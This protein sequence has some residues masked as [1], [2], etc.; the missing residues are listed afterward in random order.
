MTELADIVIALAILLSVVCWAVSAWHIVRGRELVAYAGRRPVPWSAVDLLFSL[1]ILVFFQALG[2]QSA[3]LLRLPGPTD[4]I[5]RM[6]GA[7]AA[8]LLAVAASVLVVVWNAGAKTRDLGIDGRRI[9]ADV[10]LGAVAFLMLAP[11]V[12]ALQDWLVRWFPSE[13]PLLSLLAQHGSL[14][15]YLS[16]GFSAVIVAPI[17]EEWLFR[18][19]LQGWI[20]RLM[21]PTEPAAKAAPAR[22]ASAESS[23][24][25]PHATGETR[26]LFAAA[27]GWLA[28]ITS[29]AC[30]A[31]LHAAHGPDPIPLF[32]LAAGLGYLYQRT[33]RILPCITVHV[34]LNGVTLAAFLLESQPAAVK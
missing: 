14:P 21:L 15:V 11:P 27:P 4:E 9:V 17:V 33:H 20:E 26:Q 29:A 32:V 24:V 3:M 25:I 1:L 5:A 2:A 30:F 34:L 22:L 7:A 13:H 6:V 31:G 23:R 28:I 8:N 10:G 16:V 12:Y 18:V 19:L